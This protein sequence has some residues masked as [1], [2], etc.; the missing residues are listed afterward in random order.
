MNRT[1]LIS[2]ARRVLNL[3]TAPYHEQHV[4]SFIRRECER[5]GLKVRADRFGNLFVHYRRG[6]TLRGPLAFVAHMDHPGF[7]ITENSCNGSVRAAFLGGI[8]RDFV[9]N[10][11]VRIF[12]EQEVT[13]RVAHIESWEPMEVWK[14]SQIVRLKL[15]GNVKRGDFGMWD[16]TPI[17]VRGDLLH[18]RGCDDVVGCV[19]LLAALNDLVVQKVRSDVWFVFTRAEEVG[20]HGALALAHASGLPKSVR[21][22][23]VET[24]KEIPPRAKMGGGP[25]VRVGDT[26]AVFDSALTRF[27]T[28]VAVEMHKR[29]KRFQYQRCLMDGG[30]CEATAFGEN[31]YQASGLCIALGNYHNMG[32]KHRVA[33]EYVSVSDL[34]NEVRLIVA[35][36]E[37]S[38][39][40]DTYTARLRHRLDDMHDV[41]VRRLVPS[42]NLLS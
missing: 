19:A 2:L 5:L 20:F 11:R 32:P 42:F 14:K 30:T 39:Q 24:S 3:P 10:A 23:S 36:V 7:E 12:G 16:L 40:Y 33:E 27:L 1:R 9:P 28:I 21:I 29:D 17:E 6:K 18:S 13:A 34:H 38:P 22:V 26:A 41:A 15:R 31:G 37:S 4:A 35:A 25:I 8:H